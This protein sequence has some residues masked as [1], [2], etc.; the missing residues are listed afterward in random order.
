MGR[1]SGG[2][3][4]PK[5]RIHSAPSGLCL[6]TPWHLR[7]WARVFPVSPLAR[8]WAPLSLQ[9]HPAPTSQHL[10]ADEPPEDGQQVLALPL[11][12]P[13]PLSPCGDLRSRSCP[14]SQ[15][16]SQ[17]VHPQFLW[18]PPPSGNLEASGDT[19]T[20]RRQAGEN[21]PRR[22]YSPPRLKR[23]S[24]LSFQVAGTTGTRHYPQ[25]FR[26]PDPVENAAAITE[27][28][29]RGNRGPNSGRVLCSEFLL[30]RPGGS[31]TCGP[32]MCAPMHTAHLA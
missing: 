30:E 5:S 11:T 26:N 31:H 3:S 16:S 7:G 29:I 25:S 13:P 6:E 27:T 20:T 23:S 32:L 17:P 15:S 18:G 1:L 10:P 24:C 8:N 14:A 4:P 2:W 28:Q 12:C 21:G 9:P 19:E 22:V